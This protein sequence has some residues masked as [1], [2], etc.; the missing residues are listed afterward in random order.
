MT[1]REAAEVKNSDWRVRHPRA[2]L[3][4]RFSAVWLSAVCLILTCVGASYANTQSR[5]A[6]QATEPTC[7]FK[8][9]IWDEERVQG[10]Y[11]DRSSP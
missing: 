10:F 11:L 4:K 6:H 1:R 5:D 8:L 7:C 3:I 2:T 9:S